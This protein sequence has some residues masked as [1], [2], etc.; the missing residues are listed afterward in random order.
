MADRYYEEQIVAR[1]NTL[2]GG[3]ARPIVDLQKRNLKLG[4]ELSK[5]DCVK[6]IDSLR[7]TFAQIAGEIV[8]E[9]LHKE[10]LTIIK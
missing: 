2:M 10:L 4:D 3:L 9:K 6:L 5:E 1:L 7:T 8:S